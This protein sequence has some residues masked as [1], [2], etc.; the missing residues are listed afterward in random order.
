MSKTFGSIIEEVL[1]NTRGFTSSSDQLTY[2]T[3]PMTDTATT[4]QVADASILSSGVIEVGDELMWVSSIDATS[5]SFTVLP[6]GRGYGGTTPVAH[7]ANDT[8]AISPSYPRSRIKNAVND[9]IAALWPALYSVATTEFLQTDLVHYGW[10]I[11]AEA[12]RI[13]DV[14]YKDTRGNWQRVRAWEVER[15]SNLTDFPSGV[16]LLI[17]QNIPSAS[18]I[19]VIYGK[20]PTLLNAETDQWS[21]TGYDD[22][23]ADLVVLAVLARLIPMLD[24][25]RLTVNA[26]AS[27]ELDQPR[28]LGSAVQIANQFRQQYDK[29]LEVERSVLNARYPARIHITR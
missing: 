19:R 18:S 5:G 20:K 10:E 15:S 13:L 14:R 29:R 27:D 4:G 25:A 11:P 3:G 8:V 22:Q 6:R 17:R 26:V 7:A 21:T 23:V 12:E 16:S 9:A 2:L 28:A 1:S 24:V